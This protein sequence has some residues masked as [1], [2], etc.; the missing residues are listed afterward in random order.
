MADGALA[1]CFEERSCP[2]YPTDLL[3]VRVL[4]G[5]VEDRSRLGL[6]LRTTPVRAPGDDPD[7]NCVSWMQDA[8]ARVR[9]DG[10]ALG[11]SVLDWETVRDG[12]MDYCRRK[13]AA[14]RF[15]LLADF[16]PRLV[17][18]YDLLEGKEIVP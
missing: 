2:L 13:Q 1:W 3:L 4:I 7:W 8:L 17:A 18:T 5:K 16:D 15:D 6:I 12:A 11:A 9:K 14:N 10:M